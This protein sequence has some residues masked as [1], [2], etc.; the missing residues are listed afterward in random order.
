MQASSAY[1]YCSLV[2]LI[3]HTSCGAQM[4]TIITTAAVVTSWFI[5]SISTITTVTTGL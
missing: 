3:V 1:G 4:A 5:V 2:I